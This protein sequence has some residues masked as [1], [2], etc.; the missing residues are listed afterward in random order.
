MQQ[1]RTTTAQVVMEEPEATKAKARLRLAPTQRLQCLTVLQGKEARGALALVRGELM[2][3]MVLRDLDTTKSQ[4][5]RTA[6]L[7][8]EEGE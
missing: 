8:I 5:L 6:V 4:S 2:A 7:P 1:R 3:P